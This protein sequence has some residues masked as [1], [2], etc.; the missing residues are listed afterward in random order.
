MS[1]KSSEK[2]VAI[3]CNVIA[4]VAELQI[5]DLCGLLSKQPKMSLHPLHS[6]FFSWYKN[7]VA[8]LIFGVIYFCG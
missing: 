8:S 3:N 7:F 4:G 1:I 5:V 6:E 2:K